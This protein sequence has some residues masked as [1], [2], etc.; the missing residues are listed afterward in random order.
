MGKSI[1]HD[2]FVRLR[3][4]FP[5]FIYEGFDYILNPEGLSGNFLFR[6]GDRYRFTP[7]FVI[8]RKPFF[9][10]DEQ[11]LPGLPALLFNIGMI[12]LLSYWKAACPPVIEVRPS[13]LSEEQKEWWKGVYYNGLGEFFYLNGISADYRDFVNFSTA[14][15][16]KEAKEITI[17]G[18]GT[19]IPVGGGKDS[20]VTLEL[21]GKSRG[22]I[23][24][25]MNPTSAS[26]ECIRKSGSQD[27]ETIEIRRSLDPLL[28]GLNDQGFLN[29]HTP[30]SAL[31]AFYTLLAAAVS[32]RKYIALSNESSANEATIPGTAINHQYSKSIEFE[33]GF[34][35]YVGK[36]L[37]PDIEYFSFLRPLH[38]IRIAQLFSRYPQ[39][40]PVFRSCNAGSK[41]GTW[42]GKCSKCLFTYIILSPFIGEGEL[43]RIFGRD[44]FDDPALLGY[45]EQLTGM[46]PEKPFDCVGTIGEVNAAVREAVRRREGQPLPVL[47]ERYV[48]KHGFPEEDHEIRELL[49]SFDKVHHLPPEFEA[50]LKNALHG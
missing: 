17:T 37:S 44:L 22:G 10:P 32:G 11:I 13:G 29:G 3:E 4:E 46:S 33:S 26:R 25:V 40:F 20:V 18:E 15:G 36:F 23:P 38:E 48:A 41:S 19:I 7:S 28:Y 9:L 42:C 2:K 35:K 12:E 34:R 16:A 21:L 6:L 27:E 14:E 49:D 5:V 30:F 43:I 8:P 24:L 39:Y 1:R 50:V 47:L 31:L 45:F